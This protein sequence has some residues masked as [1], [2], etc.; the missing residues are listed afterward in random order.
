MK[1]NIKAFLNSFDLP[2]VRENVNKTQVGG[3]TE[4]ILSTDLVQS[5]QDTYFHLLTCSNT[6][7]DLLR[8]IR[9][10]YTDTGPPK[11]RYAGTV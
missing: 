10:T 9:T 4:Q 1:E 8:Y 7:P 6:V 5:T 3:F 2:S 11:E